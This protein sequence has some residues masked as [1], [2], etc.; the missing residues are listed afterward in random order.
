MISR[1][2]GNHQK[3]FDFLLREEDEVVKL[4]LNIF[5][6]V[7]ALI[8]FLVISLANSHS[9]SGGPFLL[10]LLYRLSKQATI[11][12][13]QFCSMVDGGLNMTQNGF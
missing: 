6:L 2:W 11:L 12:S 9:E 1:V 10:S 13:R 4:V 7:V 5:L 3:I 8:T